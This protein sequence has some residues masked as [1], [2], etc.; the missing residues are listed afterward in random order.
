MTSSGESN[1]DNELDV[2]DL[3]AFA[4]SCCVAKFCILMLQL[5]LLFLAISIFLLLA[6]CKVDSVCLVYTGTCMHAS[7]TLVV[8]W[9]VFL[10]VLLYAWII[11][12]TEP[13]T[14]VPMEVSEVLKWNHNSVDVALAGFF[15]RKK[16]YNLIQLWY[17]SSVSLGEC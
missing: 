12:D 16:G 17:L 14:V 8:M 7:C 15:T 10:S 6:N 2:A 4:R 1:R 3:V 13:K 5:S 9:Y 11:S